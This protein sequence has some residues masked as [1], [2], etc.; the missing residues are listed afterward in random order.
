[1]SP[2]KIQV[3]VAR[4]NASDGRIVE[5]RG[6]VGMLGCFVYLGAADPKPDFA[7]GRAEL[8]NRSSRDDPM[9]FVKMVHAADHQVA[10]T[11]AVARP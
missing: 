1:M 9:H 2:P 4:S 3:D 11:G 5:R 10:L 7:L 6:R 8:L